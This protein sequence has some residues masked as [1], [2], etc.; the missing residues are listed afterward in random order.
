MNNE[1]SEQAEKVLEYY[2]ARCTIIEKSVI[3]DS[4]KFGDK[5]EEISFDYDYL[6]EHLEE[7]NG[8]IQI[9]SAAKMSEITFKNLKIIRGWHLTNN[10]I[11][12]K[13]IAGVNER[14]K[15]SKKNVI[16]LV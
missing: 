2:Y 14:G 11:T 7:I 10:N 1:A 12:N 8:G 16:N 6:F 9:V 3:I 13:N 15:L 4:P 5:G